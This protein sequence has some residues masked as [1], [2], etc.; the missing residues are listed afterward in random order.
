MLTGLGQESDAVE[1]TT[2]KTKTTRKSKRRESKTIEASESEEEDEAPELPADEQLSLDKLEAM[3]SWE[4]LISSID[5][6]ERRNDGSLQIYLTWYVQRQF[7]DR[8]LFPFF[9]F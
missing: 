7:A 1:T 6:I 5:T 9:F 2:K 8:I 3:D 4:D